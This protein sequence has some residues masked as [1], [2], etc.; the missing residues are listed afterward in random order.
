[1]AKLTAVEYQEKH[2]R[3]LKASID[4]MR[5]GIEAV[6]QSPTAKAAAKVDKMR[7]NINAA[8]DSGKWA[9]GLNRVTVDEWKTKMI[10]KGLNRVASG[11]D[12]AADKVIAFANE[13]LPHIEKGVTDIKKMPDTTLEDSIARMTS[14]TRH[15]AK[16]KRK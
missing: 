12:G 6:T 15:M 5:K 10:D 14:F 8:L 1:M 16:F 4:D 3:R 2:A 13:L 9:A 11:I 7:T